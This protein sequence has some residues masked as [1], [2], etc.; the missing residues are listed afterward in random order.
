MT[1]V[2]ESERILG[3]TRGVRCEPWTA[4]VVGGGGGSA[5]GGQLQPMSAA[6][7][8]A[9]Q[10]QAWDEAYAEGRRSGRE[11]GYREGQARARL[12]LEPLRDRCRALLD[13]L[14]E[15]L[16]ALDAELEQQLVGLALAVAGPLVRREIRSDPGVVVGAVREALAALPGTAR[17]VR[18]YVNPDDLELVRE[19]LAI[20]AGDEAWRLAE[21]PALERGGCRIESESSRVDASIETR[22]TAI[23]TQI[24]GGERAGESR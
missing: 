6:Q 8:E 10:K 21:D 2:T 1:A 3:A 14:A 18:V 24:F 20:D 5:G 11:K 19:A 13:L 23:A 12:E 22:L 7:L 9:L 17:R 16:A 15:P 4:P